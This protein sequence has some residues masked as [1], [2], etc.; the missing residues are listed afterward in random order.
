MGLAKDSAPSVGRHVRYRR[1]ETKGDRGWTDAQ[2]CRL[3]FFHIPCL[4][5]IP[6]P[7]MACTSKTCSSILYRPPDR[8]LRRHCTSHNLTD[9]IAL[10]CCMCTCVDSLISP[11]HAFRTRLLRES[12][13][14]TCTKS[15]LAR[16]PFLLLSLACHKQTDTCWLCVSS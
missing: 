2:V 14:C 4:P 5:C 7:V 16:S 3:L 1:V 15:F 10:T 6:A 12:F 8:L 11:S 9:A 13:C